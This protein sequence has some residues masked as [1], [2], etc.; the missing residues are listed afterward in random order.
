[1]IQQDVDKG[2]KVAE[3]L[4]EVF[5]TK[6][7]HGYTVSP[8]DSVPYGVTKG[9]LK[10]I[11]FLTLT[12]SLDYQRN[13]DAL[14]MNSRLTFEDPETQYLFD[15][16]SL[17]KTPLQ[18]VREDMR[19]YGLSQKP[20]KDAHIWRTVG[21]TFHKQ[22]GGDPRNLLAA[23]EWDA[24]TVLT[25][26]K[27]STHIW[28]G[29]RFVDYPYLRGNKIGPLWLRM[30]WDNAGF[31]E[32]QNLAK[33]PIPVDIHV[34]RATLALGVVHGG[35]SGRLDELFKFVRQAWFESVTGLRVCDREMIALDV[36]E[37]LWHL[38][39]HGCTKRNSETGRC[40]VRDTCE[41]R[42]FCTNG[43]IGILKSKVELQT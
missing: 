42:E 37:P 23:C 32:L 6:G 30:L 41:A 35:Y 14:W 2:H 12:V 27:D 8:E 7:I 24:L 11:L 21:V 43:R 1:M 10:H 13:A 5:A 20:N 9:S 18:K 4:C 28:N 22:W 31:T 40:S 34:A 39:K 36:D 16:S 19:R 17:H 33:V 3:L 38:S 25:R 15:P 26:L 29:R